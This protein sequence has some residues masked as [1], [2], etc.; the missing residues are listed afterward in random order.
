MTDQKPSEKQDETVPDKE[1]PEPKPSAPAEEVKKE[2][3]DDDRFQATD[4]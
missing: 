3:E 4:N 1:Q 2:I